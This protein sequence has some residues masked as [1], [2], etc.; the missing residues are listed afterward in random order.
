[1]TLT[2]GIATCTVVDRVV[3]AVEIALIVAFAGVDPDAGAAYIPLPS[4]VPK[5]PEPA[6]D[7]VTAS[8]AENC[9]V[10]PSGTFALDGVIVSPDGGGGFELTDWQPTINPAVANVAHNVIANAC[11][12]RFLRTMPKTTPLTRG[13][14]HGSNGD[15]F[16]AR[17]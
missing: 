3:S 15:R 2:A 7:H 12:D 8:D 4:I 11:L 10:P 5:D 13:K 17:R 6:T 1:L 14:V 9:L 16:S